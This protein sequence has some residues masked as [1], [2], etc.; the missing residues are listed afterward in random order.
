M[1][2]G[3]ARRKRVKGTV[4]VIIDKMFKIDFIALSESKMIQLQFATSRIKIGP[5]EPEIQAAYGAQR[6]NTGPMKS[7]DVISLPPVTMSLVALY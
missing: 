1:P 3:H 4:L 5:L 7:R 6:H 2:Y